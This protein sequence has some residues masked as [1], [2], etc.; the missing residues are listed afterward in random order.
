MVVI[1]AGSFMMGSRSRFLF[2]SDGKNPEEKPQHLVK[3]PSFLMGKTEVTQGQWKSVMG[4]NPSRFTECGDVCPVEQVSWNDVQDFIRKLNQLTGQNYRL[5][6]EAEWEYAARAGTTTEWSFAGEELKL[7]DYAWYSQN[8]GGKTREVGQ[9]LPNT[10]GL[11]DMHGNVGEWIQDCWHEN[12]AEAPTD[13]SAWMKGCG[14]NYG[15]SRGG[16]W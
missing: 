9:K 2:G 15:L 14:G 3:V 5:P 16:S 13:G 6:S 11:F 1:P 4:S 7:R 8:S 12:Y 10:F